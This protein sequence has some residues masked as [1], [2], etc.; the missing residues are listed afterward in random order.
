MFDTLTDLRFAAYGSVNTNSAWTAADPDTKS[1]TADTS[2][3]TF[4]RV[5][6]ETLADAEF[7]HIQEPVT[8]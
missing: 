5:N 3:V 8:P 1:T 7:R 2:S 4:E 6:E